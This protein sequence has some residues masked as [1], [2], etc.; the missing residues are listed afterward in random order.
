MEFNPALK[1]TV[2]TALIMTAGGAALTMTSSVICVC[3][4]AA[5][6]WLMASSCLCSCQALKSTECLGM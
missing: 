1:Q 3:W 5:S 2:R 6:S 4:E